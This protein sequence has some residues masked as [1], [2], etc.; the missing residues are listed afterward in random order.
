L[1]PGVSFTRRVEIDRDRT[2][3]FMGEEGRVYATPRLIGDIEYTCRDLI[4]QH[5]D[6]GEDSVGMEVSVKHLAATLPGSTVE[7]C[8]TV[9]EVDRRKIVFDV[10]A[11]DEV[12]PI[13]AGTHARFVVESAKTIERLKQKAAKRDAAKAGG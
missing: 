7:I 11:K 13:S 5:A 2:I 8:V 1:K 10:S 4:L 9:K 3:S 6:P 12:E